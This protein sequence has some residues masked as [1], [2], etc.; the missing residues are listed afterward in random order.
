MSRLVSTITYM[1]VPKKERNK[2]T[3][4]KLFD[5]LLSY[6][7]KKSIPYLAFED[8]ST[9]F[10]EHLSKTRKEV[11]FPKKFHGRIGYVCTKPN[12]EFPL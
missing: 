6:M 2:G 5:A 4:T 8:Y 9:G 12:V 7:K 1:F 10:W 3:G 11:V